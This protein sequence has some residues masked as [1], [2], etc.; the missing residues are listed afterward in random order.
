MSDAISAAKAASSITLELEFLRNQRQRLEKELIEKQVEYQSIIEDNQREIIH[1]KNVVHKLEQH[2]DAT[3]QNRNQLPG[4]L[5]LENCTSKECI[6]YI[7][8]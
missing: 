6:N 2:Q 5:S 3:K 4:I 8:D 7:R 1:L